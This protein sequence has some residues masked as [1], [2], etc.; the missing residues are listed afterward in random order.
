[1]FLDMLVAEQ[2]VCFWF[3]VRSMH[4]AFAA[5]P[6]RSWRQHQCMCVRLFLT[7]PEETCR[8]CG[9][10]L[11]PSVSSACKAPIDSGT[12]LPNIVRRSIR[13]SPPSR[14][15]SNRLYAGQ[16]PG[17]TSPS[18]TL[19]CERAPLFVEH[20]LHLPPANRPLALRVH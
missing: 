3:R 6:R 9:S 2:S 11:V 8:A 19:L 7:H 15:L 5:A 13:R 12:S 10:R 16:R 1:M 4:G 14:R 17:L 18:L 20:T